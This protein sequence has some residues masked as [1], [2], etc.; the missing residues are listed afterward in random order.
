M[1]GQW[2]QT[3]EQSW[4]D[5]IGSCW[6]AK[7]HQA[8]VGDQARTKTKAGNPNKQETGL[9]TSSGAASLGRD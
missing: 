3:G 6:Q 2:P 9:G 1:D 8:M 7:E 4:R 5:S